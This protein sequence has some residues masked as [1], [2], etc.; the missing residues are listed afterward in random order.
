M[1]IEFLYFEHCANYRQALFLLER[2]LLEEGIESPVKMIRVESDELAEEIM[3]PGSPTI[4]INGKDID[5]TDI[6]SRDG[7]EKKCRVYVDAD[8]LTG[9][10]PEWKI[11][12]AILEAKKKSTIV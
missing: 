10:P 11:R 6:G 2:I 1:K 12:N 3:F 8:V 5:F 9:I 7:Y 4:R